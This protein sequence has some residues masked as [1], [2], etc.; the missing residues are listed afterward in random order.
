MR[1]LGA[2]VRMDWLQLVRNPTA[3]FMVLALP[4]GLLLLQ[5]YLIPGTRTP[6]DADGRTALDHF[7]AV[8]LIVAAMSVA[9]TNYPASIAG[10]RETGMLRRLD[11]TPAGASRI[12]LSQWV[13]SIGCLLL[14]MI[15]LCVLEVWVIGVPAPQS[16]AA[17]ILIAALGAMSLMTL[18]SLIAAVAATVPIAY[19]AGALLF[20]LGLLFSGVWTPGPLMPQGL[21]DVA[22]ATPPGAMTQG[23]VAAWFDGELAAMTIVVLIGWTIVPAAFAARLFRWR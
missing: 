1:E 18:G 12:L 16:P 10:Y 15:A 23:I 4:F 6:L 9:L 22:S 3:L 17:V 21:R 8:A 5:A 14:G 20:M 11:A 13:V 7:A 2:L 19:G